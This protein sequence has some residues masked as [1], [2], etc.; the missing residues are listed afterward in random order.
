MFPKRLFSDLQHTTQLFKVLF[1]PKEDATRCSTLLSFFDIVL[2]QKK[3]LL[4]W[5]NNNLSIC[6][7]A[8]FACHTLNNFINTTSFIPNDDELHLL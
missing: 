5:I 1:P 7:V 4:P 3:Q 2:L 6:F 8:M